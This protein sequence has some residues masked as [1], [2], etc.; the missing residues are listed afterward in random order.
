MQDKI[1][2][3]VMMALTLLNSWDLKSTYFKNNLK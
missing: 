1:A 2:N 3:Q